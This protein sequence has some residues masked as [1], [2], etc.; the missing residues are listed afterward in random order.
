M[1]VIVAPSLLSANFLK[2][3]DELK[4]LNESE[5]DWLHLDVMDGRFVPNITF[6]MPIIKQINEATNKPLDV[7]LM[8]VEPEKY[9]EDFKNAGAD[10]LTVHEEV[11]VHLHRTVCRIKELGMK[12]G[13]SL[14]PHTPVEVLQD[15]LKDI[16]LVLIMS[17]NP[18]FGGQ[19]FI[20]GTYDKIKRLRKM[21]VEKQTPLIIEIDGGVTNENA[22]FLV[23]AG[24]D[25]LVAGSFVFGADD[26]KEAIK[27]LK[28]DS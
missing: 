3:G 17:V 23:D 10:I 8:I 26:P 12:A 4:M 21:A 5:A 15:I 11:S 6:G 2:L 14:N 20:E 16:D 22:K 13:V 18:G 25:A 27:S 7:H 9:L 1:S 24:A 19:S 28:I